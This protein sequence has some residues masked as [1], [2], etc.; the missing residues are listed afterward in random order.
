MGL[1]ADATAQYAAANRRCG[2]GS[3]NCEWWKPVTGSDLRI[4]STYNTYRYAGLPVRPIAN[5]GLSS[6]EAA[7]SPQ[8]NGYFYYLHD[9]EGVIHYA[10]TLTEHNSNVSK[11]LR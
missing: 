1:Q 4:D 2:I 11:Y 8:D 7:A 6:L 3:A 10:K 9:S 5:P